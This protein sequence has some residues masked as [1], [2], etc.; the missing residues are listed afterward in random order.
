M[1]VTPS[2]LVSV[3]R[4]HAGPL[5]LPPEM[6][7]LEQVVLFGDIPITDGQRP[8]LDRVS[9]GLSYT[10]LLQYK[11]GSQECSMYY[12]CRFYVATSLSKQARGIGYLNFRTQEAKSVIEAWHMHTHA[13]FPFTR[14]E[15]ESICPRCIHCG[16]NNPLLYQS[17]RF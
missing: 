11:C 10:T 14:A 17:G 13:G 3:E 15:S 8:I 1:Q 4:I 16:P 9:E 5:V 6:V 2:V 7:S 12:L